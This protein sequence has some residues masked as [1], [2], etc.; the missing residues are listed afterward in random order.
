M[1]VL[2]SACRPGPAL[3]R[4]KE[5]ARVQSLWAKNR[6]R[7]ISEIL[8]GKVEESGV[9]RDSKLMTDYW[10]QLI[11]QPSVAVLATQ[12]AAHSVKANL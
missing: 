6:S 4:R 9:G 2:P 11:S 3:S 1:R 7:A 12:E 5:Y 10:Q 8:D